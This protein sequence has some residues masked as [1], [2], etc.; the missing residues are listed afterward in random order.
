MRWTKWKPLVI[1]QLEEVPENPGV[2][3]IKA[4]YDIPRLAGKSSTLYVGSS[5]HSIYGRLSCF[6]YIRD[7]SKD[8]YQHKLVRKLLRKLLRRNGISLNKLQFRYK[9]CA[10]GKAEEEEARL[11]RNYERKHIE[12]PPF[13]KKESENQQTQHRR[14]DGLNQY[15][16]TIIA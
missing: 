7:K 15:D 4:S 14:K 12:L 2:Y 11:L 1:T 10:K 3:E 16:K 9:I 13:N 5:K 6:E 8:Y